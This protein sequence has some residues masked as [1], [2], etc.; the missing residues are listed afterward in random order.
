MNHTFSIK[1]S[2][3]QRFTS[4]SVFKKGFQNSVSLV[5]NFDLL[6]SFLAALNQYHK[7]LFST[8]VIETNQ[9]ELFVVFIECDRSGSKHK[10]DCPTPCVLWYWCLGEFMEATDHQTLSQ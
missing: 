5:T 3:L 6:F 1:I 8:N 7:I 10:G 4:A 2:I 9:T